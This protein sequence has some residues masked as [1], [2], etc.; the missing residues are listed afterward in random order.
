MERQLGFCVAVPLVAL[1]LFV[2][3]IVNVRIHVEPPPEPLK[4]LYEIAEET[5]PEPEAPPA[6]AQPIPPPPP[7]ELAATRTNSDESG[8][9]ILDPVVGEDSPAAPNPLAELAVQQPIAIQDWIPTTTD[10]AELESIRDEAQR[11]RMQLER[12]AG[13]IREFIIRNE[14][15]S[16]AKDFELNSDGGTQGAIRLLNLEGGFPEEIVKRVLNRYG[17]KFDHRYTKPAAGRNFLNAAQTTGGNFTNVEKEGYFDV[18][19]LSQKALAMMTT[20][21]IE[22]MQRRGYDP[23]NTRVRKIVFGI[24][25]RNDGEYDLDVTA[26]EA[27]RI[28]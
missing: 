4:V 5:P 18:L 20:R 22:A 19:V 12:T 9:E 10:V 27:E 23:V 6:P 17:V 26:F 25:M 15:L 8:V 24:V 28:R 3:S 16:A 2:L 13:D 14:V 7:M 21:E 11:D 1:A